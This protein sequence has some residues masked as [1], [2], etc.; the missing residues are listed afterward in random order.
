MIV[1]GDRYLLDLAQ[2]RVVL[3]AY[4]GTRPG[5]SQGLFVSEIGVYFSDKTPMGRH[6]HS[7]DSRVL[8]RFT[9]SRGGRVFTAGDFLDLGSRNTVDAALSRQAR[10]GKIRK[11]ARGL[12]DFPKRDPQLGLLMPSVEL[13]AKAL[14]GRDAVRLQP[15]GAYAANRLGLSEQV[16]MK[17]LFLTDGAPRRVRIGKLQII[18]RRTTPRNMAT[19]G[20]ISG[21]VIQALRYLGQRHVD[22]R[23]V[24]ILRGRLSDVDK[25]Q[26]LKDIR[27]APVWMAN[28]MQQVAAPEVS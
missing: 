26:L 8:R 4:S 24:T 2:Q 3:L 13:V 5:R 25:R 18:I 19:A 7:I 21:L 1:P 20:R 6:A 17:V 22:D 28:I 12:Y 11:L 10:T 15:S 23:V 16:P 14:R 9:S 27:F